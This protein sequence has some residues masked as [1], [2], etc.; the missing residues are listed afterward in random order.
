MTRP[1]IVI[2][3]AQQFGRAHLER[4]GI[5][6]IDVAGAVAA[7]DPVAEVAEEYGLTRH[8]VLLACWHEGGDGSFQELWGEWSK[9]VHEALASWEPYDLAT[10][11]DPP[12]RQECYAY[13]FEC[14]HVWPTARCLR[15]S[16]RAHARRVFPR[17]QVAARWMTYLTP[18]RFIDFCPRCLHDL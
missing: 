15:R 16:Y 11:P 9:R 8:E 2:D 3:P 12:A 10:V 4:T 17:S 14:D 1:R 5:K 13:C 7:G 18:A 6:T